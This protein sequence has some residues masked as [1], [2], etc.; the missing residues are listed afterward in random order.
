MIFETILEKGTAGDLRVEAM[1]LQRRQMNSPSTERARILAIIPRGEVIRNFI[2]S[3]ALDKMAA[4]AD[5]SLLS[6][7]PNREL[8]E[9][10]RSRF[11]KVFQ[12]HELKEK[13]VVHIQR[14]ILDLAHGRWLWSEAARER[15]R[16]RDKEADTG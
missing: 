7:T 11:G 15:W 5:L 8:E 1:R 3:E 9:L 12:L 4:E 10:L 6:V 2:Y 16:L 14:E 13:W